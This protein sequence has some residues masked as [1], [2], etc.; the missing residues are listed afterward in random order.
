MLTICC[1]NLFYVGID[2]YH[3]K[4]HFLFLIPP[5]ISVAVTICNVLFFSTKV[6]VM[7]HSFILLKTKKGFQ[8]LAQGEL[9][10]FLPLS[11]T[12]VCVLD[13]VTL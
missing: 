12:S 2:G 13:I 4:L 10:Y 7:Q 8:C 9:C 3:Y 1:R 5:E 11:L 6:V